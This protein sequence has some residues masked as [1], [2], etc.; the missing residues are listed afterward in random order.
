MTLRPHHFLLI[1]TAGGSLPAWAEDRIDFN[2]DI[3]PILSNNCLACHG[4]DEAKRKAKLRLDSHAGAIADLGGY[5]AVVPGDLEA[6]ELIARITEPDEE[7]RMPPK[8]KGP[9]LSPTEIDLLKRWVA[10]GGNYARHW[11]YEIPTRPALPKVTKLSWVENPIDQFILSHHEARKL[12]PSSRADRWTLARR[13]STDLTGL[14]P[15]PEEA[16]AFVND[17]SADAFSRYVDRLLGKPTYGEHW[18]RLWLDLARYADSAG[19]ADDPRRTIWGYRDWVIRAI[20]V[21]MPFD[22]FTI[23]QLAGD[24]LEAPSNDQLVATAFHR[25]TLTNSEGGTND[26]EFRNA[27]VIDR[28]NTT[29]QTWMGT[30][31][32]CAQCHTHKYDPITQ[33]EFFQF[34][35]F[36]N[37][38]EDADRKNETPIVQVYTPEQRQQ[39][40]KLREEA[41]SL[42][43]E[44]TIDSSELAKEQKSWEQ[45]VSIPLLWNA[46]KPGRATA[47]NGTT[48]TIDN[49]GSVTAGGKNPAKSVYT[50]EVPLSKPLHALRLD[51]L[52][53][54]GKVSRGDNLVISKI[55]ATYLPP[56][57]SRGVRGRYVRVELPGAGKFLHLAEVEVFSGS[58]NVARQGVASQISTGFNGPARLAIDGNTNGDFNG[59]KSTSHTAEGNDPW[60]EVDLG[61]LKEIDRVMIW[62]RTDGGTQS[63]LAGYKVAILDAN[64]RPVWEQTPQGV[65]SPSKGFATSGA[66]PINFIAASADFAQDKFGAPSVLTSKVDPGKG[67]AVAPRFD[68]RHHL[69]LLLD[70]PLPAG[71]SIVLQIHHESN[72]PMTT[73]AKFG[74][75]STTG[76]SAAARI[77]M[78]AEVRQALASLSPTAAQKEALGNFYRTIAPATAGTQKRLAEIERLIA[79]I[80]PATTVPVMRDLAPNKKRKTHVQIRGDYKVKSD[81]VSEGTPKAFHP[82]PEGAPLNR[83]TLAKWIVSRQNPLTARV[84]A[85][86]QWEAIFGT[87]IVAT[88]EEFGSQGEF[89]SHPALLDWL[90]VELMESGWDLKHLHKLIVTSATYQQSSRV[91]PELLEADPFNHLLTRGPRQRLSAEM[92]RDQALFA[93]GLL[94]KKMYGPPTRPPRPKLGL[95]AAFGGS[96]DWTDSEGEDRYRRGVYTEWRRSMPYPSMATFDAPNREVCTVRRSQTNTPLQAL[97]TLNDPVYVEA[98]QALARRAVKESADKDPNAIASRIL[99]L[100]LVRPAKP[101]E[102]APLTEFYQQAYQTFLADPQSAAALATEPLGKP[103]DGADLI[104]LA[105]WTAVANVALNLDEIIQKP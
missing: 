96:T 85:N 36:F 55:A 87:G 34:S 84:I 21:N 59:A 94:S 93:A 18:A 31:I 76:S 15:S 53:V 26:E 14:P 33:H 10:Q 78:P 28:V 2:R 46:L 52:T 3:R 24:L 44:L 61:G 101:E 90:A 62:N 65:P 47:T 67:W 40:A 71:G 77:R 73:L 63:R 89:P 102:L 95:K 72:W 92:I 29:M 22:Q 23:E 105:A 80:K 27:A 1:L 91:T 64:R 54:N 79:A 82:L 11:S 32:A 49:S 39:E 98:A 100:A 8:S 37:S 68:K 17:K 60:W 74:L 30:T 38:T 57:S 48:L 6:S 41:G 66:R 25:N 5:A 104:A 88:S 75:S 86:R 81:E 19:Y 4:P 43:A 12:V 70:Q 58:D 35:A 97:V 103:A 16:A 69:L 9:R 56:N 7:E 99:Q 45:E 20:N 51:A 42:R 50:L 13:A 83:L